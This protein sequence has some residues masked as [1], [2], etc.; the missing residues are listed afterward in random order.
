MY[1]TQAFADTLRG[2]QELSAVA[3]QFGIETRDVLL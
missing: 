2:L 1:Q 3:T